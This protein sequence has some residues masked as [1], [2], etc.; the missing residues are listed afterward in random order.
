MTKKEFTDA[1]LKEQK[2]RKLKKAITKYR[3]ER[4]MIM[5]YRK[6]K[7]RRLKGYMK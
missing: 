4:D 3:N 2:M 6:G 5:D 7:S 1:F